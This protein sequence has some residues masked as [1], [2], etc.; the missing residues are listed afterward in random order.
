MIRCA[1]A[2]V[3]KAAGTLRERCVGFTQ[4]DPEA[5]QQISDL[6]RSSAGGE[7][8]AFSR[9]YRLT[10]GKMRKTALAVLPSADVEDV[11]QEAY[12]KIWCHAGSFDPARSSPISWMSVIVRNTA[13]DA[14]RRIRLPTTELERAADVAEDS[15]EIDDFD[16]VFARRIANDVLAKLPD[17]RRRLL[18]L[19]YVDGYSRTA[20]AKKLGTPTGTIKT[21]LR[22]TLDGVK[23]DC[24]ALARRLEPGLTVV[25]Q[26]Q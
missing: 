17:D 19:A 15:G 23:T 16:Y 7:Q 22:R 24:A 25:E 6:I 3:S 2:S 5:R 21:W 20:I 18:S 14:T 13:L 12:L 8:A 1:A 4:S 11:L 9:L 10:R 26:N